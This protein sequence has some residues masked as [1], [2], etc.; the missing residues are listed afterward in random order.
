[1]IPGANGIPAVPYLPVA[2]IALIVA[3]LPCSEAGVES[4]LSSLGLVF[5]DHRRSIQDDLIEA[6]LVVRLPGIPN[7]PRS[8]QVLDK[9]VAM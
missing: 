6:L 4:A 2:E 3:R 9:C 1:V 7:V 8:S 5:G